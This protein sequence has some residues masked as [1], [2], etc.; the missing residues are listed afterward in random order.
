[1][2]LVEVKDKQAA[3]EFLQV[4]VELYK[5][6]ANWIR[7]LDKDIEQVFDKKKNKA[8]QY[9]EAIRWILKDDAGQLI[10]R[11]AA[12]VNKRYKSKGDDIPVGGVG[13]RT[14]QGL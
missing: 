14:H 2:Q 3:K 1:M 7:P 5:H 4:A 13:S 6:D 8:F 9:G 12:F 10:G 11:I